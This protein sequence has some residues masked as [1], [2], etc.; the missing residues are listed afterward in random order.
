VNL[1]RFIP[2]YEHEVYASGKEPLLLL[3]LSFLLAFALT[4]IYTRLARRHSWGSGRLGGIHVHHLVPGLILVLIA[5]MIG[6]SSYQSPGVVDGAAIAFGFGAALVLDEFALVFHLEDV[7]W[8]HEG[9][10]SVVATVLGA[11]VVTLLLVVTAPFGIHNEAF[12]DRSRLF[13]FVYLASN[14]L[15][16]IISFLKGKPFVGLAAIFVPF[17]GLAG[18]VRLAHPSSPWA[19]MFYDGEKR[20]R[21]QQRF[22]RCLGQRT[23]NRVVTTLGGFQHGTHAGGT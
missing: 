12:G 20:L 16:A 21:A 8:E 5:G 10:K 1:F 11:A 7:Y 19:H 2:G 4:R 15:Y 6:F 23:R 17:A 9:R 13:A 22:R 3:L 18:A 14:S